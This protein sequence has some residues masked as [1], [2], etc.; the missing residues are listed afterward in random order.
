MRQR[1]LERLKELR[2]FGKDFF[3]PKNQALVS[4]VNNTRHLAKDALAAQ[5]GSTDWQYWTTFTTAYPLTVKS[6]RRRMEKV[7][8]LLNPGGDSQM[9]WAAEPFDTRE[10][11]HTHALLKVPS[12]TTTKQIYDCWQYACGGAYTPDKLTDSPQY[13]N[14]R[15]SVEKFNPK[16]G[17]GG[18]VGKYIQKKGA[19]YDW[20]I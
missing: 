1:D 9:F 7:F 15:V 5:L 12:L 3:K 10:G 8:N 17:A 20:F 14:H 4:M 13:L 11:Y 16:M 18:Y 2:N 19:D 6:A